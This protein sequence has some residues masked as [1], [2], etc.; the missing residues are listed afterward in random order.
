MIF[1]S[2]EF[3]VFFVVVF[4]VYGLLKHR[5]QN[6]WLLAA[7]YLFYGAWDWRFLGLILLSTAVDYTVGIRLFK[8]QNPSIRF[9]WVSL[10][11]AIN[12]G[13]LGYFKYAGFFVQSFIELLE[14]LDVSLSVDLLH[15]V[16]PVGISFYTF[17]TLSYTVDIYRRR[18]EPERNVLNFALFVA[19]FPQL[20]AG[21]IERATRL[22]PQIAK[23]RR[24]S[25]EAISEGSW[26][27]FWGLFKKVVIGDNLGPLVNAVY[28]PGASPSGPEVM[29][30]TYAFAV[31][32]YCDFSGYTDIARGIAKIL[33]FDLMLNFNL[34][35]FARNPADF[36]RRWHIS[37]STWLRDYL[38]ISLGGNRRGSTRTYINLALTM[39]LGGLW[40]GAAWNFVVWGAYQGFLLIVHRACQ[41]PLQRLVPT[42]SLGTKAWN[43]L[44]IVVTFQ[45]VCLG[46][47]I[48]RADSVAQIGFLLG[49]L[50]EPWNLGLVPAWILPFTLLTAPLIL[51]QLAQFTTGDLNCIQRCPV[52]LRAVIYAVFFLVLVILG[53]DFGQ[54]FI[55]F[56]F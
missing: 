26:L 56:Q 43:L 2:L 10:S 44:S 36:W 37:L 11:L 47:M 14:A 20:V 9:R 35:Y 18:L 55:Y 41:K 32:I 24:I 31:Q 53:E 3:A 39:L 22:L 50:F 28:A 8:E 49:R 4:L 46:W 30:A 51:M 29:L 6:L 34:P 38:Y 17:Q 13:I 25:F 1:N 16:L 5:L 42:S 27:V 52:L 21:P 45:W 19:F 54:P 7:S 48:F 12:L 33:G 40:H 23:P 15:I